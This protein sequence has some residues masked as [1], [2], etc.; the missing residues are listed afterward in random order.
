MEEE[1]ISVEELEKLL[2]EL[3]EKQKKE[4]IITIPEMPMPVPTAEERETSVEELAKKF[5][6]LA[7]RLELVEKAM[8]KGLC[9]HVKLPFA[10]DEAYATVCRYHDVD[11][12]TAKLLIDLLFKYYKHATMALQAF[13]ELDECGSYSPNYNVVM[14]TDPIRL[15]VLSNEADLIYVFNLQEN[16]YPEVIRVVVDVDENKLRFRS[17]CKATDNDD[18]FHIKASLLDALDMPLHIEDEDKNSM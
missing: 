4:L 16:E 7:S 2:Q 17:I 10:K 8:T 18:V 9:Y 11:E 13:D 6:E 12:Q 3:E 1:K 14:F 5:E 15:A